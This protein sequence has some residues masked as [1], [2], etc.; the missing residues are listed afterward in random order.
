MGWF[1]DIMPSSVKDVFQVPTTWKQGGALLLGGAPAQL[2]VKHDEEAAVIA[3][4]EADA[5]QAVAASWAAANPGLV[6][7]AAAVGDPRAVQAELTRMGYDEWVKTF[8]PAEGDLLAMTTYGGNKGLAGGIIADQMKNIDANTT[9]AI[10]MQERQYSRYGMN[11]TAEQA[12]QASA[13]IGMSG[14]LA[15]VDAINKTNNWQEELNRD[16]MATGVANTA[17]KPKNE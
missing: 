8:Q 14:S 11:P 12:Q 16:I 5:E 6:N 9:S 3:A 15:K 10:G 7:P 13:D 4:K 2:D 17:L 1:K